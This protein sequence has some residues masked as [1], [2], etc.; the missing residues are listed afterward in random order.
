MAHRK[1]SSGTISTASPGSKSKRSPGTLVDTAP[2]T[3]LSYFGAGAMLIGVQAMHTNLQTWRKAIDAYR[4][5]VREQQD[6]MIASMESYL[7]RAANLG[8]GKGDVSNVPNVL[9]PMAAMA[10]N[11]EEMS[12]AL[13]GA[14]R[15][16]LQSFN[17]VEKRVH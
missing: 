11:L 2:A 16:A 14:Q 17:G 12:A 5:L 1:P 7:G 13:L 4:V 10:S 3:Q 9:D 15:T 6:A 8:G